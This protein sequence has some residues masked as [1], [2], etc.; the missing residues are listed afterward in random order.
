M[1][2]WGSAGTQF[3]SREEGGQ[4]TGHVQMAVLKR[5]MIYWSTWI[6]K[7]LY[8]LSHETGSLMKKTQTAADWG[9]HRQSLRALSDGAL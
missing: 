1:D 7:N 5:E 2:Q 6:R 8:S 9:L 3:A 4:V